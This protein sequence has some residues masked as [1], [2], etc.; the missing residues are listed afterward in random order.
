MILIW[1]DL[2]FTHFFC[3]SLSRIC[4][5]QNLGCIKKQ[6]YNNISWK[7]EKSVWVYFFLSLHAHINNMRLD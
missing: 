3:R 4:N 6:I 1:L 5:T 7:L 2:T